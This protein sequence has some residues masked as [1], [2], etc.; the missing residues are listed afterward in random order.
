MRA[1]GIVAFLP[2]FC[3]CAGRAP[4]PVSVVQSQDRYSTCEAIMVEIEANNKQIT[5]L[6]EEKGLKVAQNVVTGL[7]GFVVPIIWFG[8]DWQ[9]TQDKE[10]QALQARQQYLATL[11]EERCKPPAPPP[12]PPRS[13]R[14]KA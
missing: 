12:P 10:V 8:M 13:R 6:G 9:G 2:V 7:A 11:A 14:P 1:W 5:T 3:A 4:Q